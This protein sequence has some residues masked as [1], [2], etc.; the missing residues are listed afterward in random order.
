MS[1][2][3]TLT[4]EEKKAGQAKLD[5]SGLSDLLDEGTIGGLSENDPAMEEHEDE[6]EG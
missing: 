3:K 6:H 4:D 5:S 2:E 1:E